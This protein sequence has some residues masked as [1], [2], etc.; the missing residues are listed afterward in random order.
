MILAFDCFGTVFDIRGLK[1]ADIH[2]YVMQVKEGRSEWKPLELPPEWS[3]MPAWPDSADAIA[4]LRMNGHT[5]VTCSNLPLGLLYYASELAGISWDAICPLE[6]AR[7]YKPDRR[8]YEVVCGVMQLSPH[9]VTVVTAHAEGPDIKGAPA[10]GMNVML[11]RQNGETLLDLVEK[12][13]D[14]A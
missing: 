1:P 7:T 2:S 14:A 11:V 6:S 5:C 8:A 13:G 3:Q 12:L 9:Q 4:Q 10:A